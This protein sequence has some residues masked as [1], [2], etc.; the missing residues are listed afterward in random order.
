M[1]IKLI[2]RIRLGLSHLRKHKFKHSFQHMLNPLLNYEIDVG[3]S[4]NFLHQCPSF[5]NERRSLMSNLNRINPQISQISQQFL[6]KA[7][8]CG[9]SS[10]SHK[11]NPHILNAT[12]DY[13]RSTKRFD[14]PLFMNNAFLFFFNLPI[15]TVISS[16]IIFL[17]SRLIFYY[18]T[19]IIIVK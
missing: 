15:G 12:I 1:C 19:L 9:N 11:M 6:T 5:I 17:R 4:T 10:Y 7:F 14:E 16:S 13:I 3:S 18:F 8:L 2:T